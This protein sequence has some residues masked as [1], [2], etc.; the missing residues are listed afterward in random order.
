MIFNETLLIE[1]NATTDEVIIEAKRNRAS[2]VAFQKHKQTS[3]NSTDGVTF[4]LVQR[5]RDAN[6]AAVTRVL[7]VTI[8]EGKYVS[9]RGLGDRYSKTLLNAADL[10]GLDTN[11]DTVQMDIFPSNLIDNITVFKNFTSDFPRSFTGVLVDIHT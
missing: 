3:V 4:D 1:E 10:P 2:D 6:A 7:G 8:E 5:T 11:K 9:A